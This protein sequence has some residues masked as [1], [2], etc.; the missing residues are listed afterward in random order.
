MLFWAFCEKRNM[1]VSV[2]RNKVRMSLWYSR[3]LWAVVMLS[4]YVVACW[5]LIHLFV[6]SAEFEA[7]GGVWSAFEIFKL[8][9]TSGL[10]MAAGIYVT[11]FMPYK[12]KIRLAI[13]IGLS[14]TVG[15]LWIIVEMI[16]KAIVSVCRLVWYGIGYV[17]SEVWDHG[18]SVFEKY[19]ILE[20]RRKRLYEKDVYK[21]IEEK[22]F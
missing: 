4:G 17:N 7:A 6:Y 18:M 1:E 22:A 15:I 16:I 8:F 14:W 11:C 20:A 2:K 19:R 21:D 12:A 13:V 3:A 9:V 5:G 10:A